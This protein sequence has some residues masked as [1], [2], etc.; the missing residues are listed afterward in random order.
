MSQSEPGL[1]T[2]DDGVCRGDGVHI[3][4][5]RDRGAGENLL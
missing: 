2:G 5:D 4:P 1:V 3:S